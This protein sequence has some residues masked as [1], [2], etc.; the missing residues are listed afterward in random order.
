MKMLLASIALASVVTVPALADSVN[1]SQNQAM[2]ARASMQ[3][4]NAMAQ[5]APL[6]R[7]HSPNPGWDVYD[8]QGAYLGSDPDPRIRSELR[9]NPPNADGAGD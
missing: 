8:S 7:A 3:P 4:A 5:S 9:R 6:R 1:K 2:N